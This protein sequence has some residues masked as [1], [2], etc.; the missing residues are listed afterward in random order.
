MD[1]EVRAGTTRFSAI[2]DIKAMQA[3]ERRRL[4]PGDRNQK[5]KN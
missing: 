3:E 2:L 4:R 5:P 1:D